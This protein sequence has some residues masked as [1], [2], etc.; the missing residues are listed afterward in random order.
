MEV[1]DI[2]II[3]KEDYE[4]LYKDRINF[5]FDS[6]YFRYA[7]AIDELKTLKEKVEGRNYDAWAQQCKGHF[8]KTLEQLVQA[9]KEN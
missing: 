1:K 5:G 7:T 3:T 8:Y 4:K 9:H 2:K 6:I